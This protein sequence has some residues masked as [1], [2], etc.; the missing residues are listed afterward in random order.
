MIWIALQQI[1]VPFF[2]PLQAKYTSL[3][4]FLTWLW[5]CDFLT[6]VMLVYKMLEKA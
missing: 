3:P 2:L 4:G 5:S 6:N 1:F